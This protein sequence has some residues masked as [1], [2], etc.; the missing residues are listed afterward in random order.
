MIIENPLHRQERGL[1][2]CQLLVVIAI[3]GTMTGLLAQGYSLVKA[4]AELTELTCRGEQFSHALELYY[5]DHRIYPTAYPATLEQDLAPYISDPHLFVDPRS[6]DGSPG[7]LNS[8]YVPPVPRD[9]NSYVLSF[10]CRRDSDLCVVLYSDSVTEIVKELE[11]SHDGEPISPG[12]RVTGGVIRFAGGAGVGLT[13]TSSATLVRSFVDPDGTLFNIIKLDSEPPHVLRAVAGGP[14]VTEIAT[15]G[16]VVFVRN[17]MADAGVAD[18]EGE[19]HLTVLA[20]GG[21][22]RVIGIPVERGVVTGSDDVPQSLEGGVNLNPNNSDDFSFFLEK[23]DG[24]TIERQDLLD[25]PQLA[26]DGPAVLARFKPKGNGNQ[27]YLLVDGEPYP[28]QNGTL[29]TIVAEDMTVYLHNTKKGRGHGMGHWWLHQI[30]A[31]EGY[32]FEGEGDDPPIEVEAV[33]YDGGSVDLGEAL[34]E[35]GVLRTLHRGIELRED[36]W[37]EVTRLY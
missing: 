36:M 21:E 2:I 29:Y 18:E 20:H 12:D 17:G 9:Q 34:V 4:T 31:S 19:A 35:G 7:V 11:V 24:S 3:I 16:G 25:D 6:P 8:S 33:T 22:V 37:I 15:P 10:G 13:D 14:E 1:G 23:P 26:Y 30:E 27:N 32:L 5:R 28:L